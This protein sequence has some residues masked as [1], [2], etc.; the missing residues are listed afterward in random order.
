MPLLKPRTIICLLAAV[1]LAV[2]ACDSDHHQAGAKPTEP[3]PAGN[4]AALRRLA[5]AFKSLSAKFDRKPMEMPPEER[6]AFVEQV[7]INA[8]YNYDATLHELATHKVDYGNQDVI[9]LVDLLTLPHRNTTSAEP[10]THIYR[11]EELKD[12]KIIEERS[13]R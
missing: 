10:D 5:E 9:D 11:P 1:A 6:K 12:I 4:H 3:V 13:T 7:F 2:T 8:G